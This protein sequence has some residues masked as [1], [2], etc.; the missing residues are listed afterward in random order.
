MRKNNFAKQLIRL[1]IN[2][3]QKKPRKRDKTA[4][5]QC[6]NRR[7]YGGRLNIEAQQY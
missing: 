3:A 6:G 5:A 2:Q 4:L 7:D 1:H